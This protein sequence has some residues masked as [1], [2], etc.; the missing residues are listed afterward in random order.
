[1]LHGNKISKLKS[2]KELNNYHRQF[3]HW[4]ILDGQNNFRVVGSSLDLNIRALQIAP[5]FAFH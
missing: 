2:N 3:L 5:I 1:M 4:F